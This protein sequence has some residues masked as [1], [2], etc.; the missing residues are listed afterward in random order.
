[1]TGLGFIFGIAQVLLSSVRSAPEDRY[2][3]KYGS[4]PDMTLCQIIKRVNIEPKRKR[5]RVEGI[6]TLFYI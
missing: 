5:E 1:M 2:R 3:I 4:P 6:K